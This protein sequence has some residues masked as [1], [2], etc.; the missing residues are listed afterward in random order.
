MARK[1]AKTMIF[2]TLEY[3]LGQ[4][5]MSKLDFAD[6]LGYTWPYIDKILHF[7][8]AAPLTFVKRLSIACGI[9]YELCGVIF[10]Y[11]PATWVNLCRSKP[12]LMKD[13]M[14]TI[15]NEVGRAPNKFIFEKKRKN[16]PLLNY[17]TVD[18]KVETSENQ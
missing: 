17:D 12:I 9:N 2:K 1:K 15:M 5:E 11:V 18:V 13:G 4:R 10:G 16:Y 14:T 6:E 7:E 3:V 8:M